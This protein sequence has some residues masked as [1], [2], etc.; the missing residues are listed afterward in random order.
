MQPNRNVRSEI[1][2]ALVVVLLLVVVGLSATLL[3]I[4]TDEPVGTGTAGTAIAGGDKTVTQVSATVRVKETLTA[5]PTV[6]TATPTD[7][8]TDTPTFTP[9]ATDT[10]TNTATYTDT[11]TA[12]DTSTNTPTPTRTTSARTPVSEEPTPT[13]TPT[14]T[15]TGTFTPTLT[16]TFTAT[17][18]P[19]ATASTPSTGVAVL[20]TTIATAA[21]C[22]QPPTWT[23]YQV[24]RGNTLF[25]IARAVG[26]SVGELKTVNC[27]PDADNIAT[28][29]VIFVPRSPN[30][31]VQTGVPRVPDANQL[32]IREGCA[33]AAS[34][35]VAPQPGQR[36]QG[37]FSLAGTAALDEFQYY[38]IEV[39]P[40]FTNVY[41]FYSQSF[42]PVNNGSL[43]AVNAEMFDDGL[44][45]LKLTVVDRT[46]NFIEP[47]VV[48]V[49][50][51]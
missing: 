20:P 13:A 5:T 18:S 46:G 35:I 49:I 4:V 32:L 16:A 40:D 28:G 2:A 30:G 34:Q 14:A 22:T 42:E 12:T 29:D 11:A 39:R 50:F 41:N 23:T 43:G 38:K 45:W 8:P 9:S 24:E 33:L 44:Y 7:T 15:D 25:S 19:T 6:A 37:T 26:S 48:P 47:C 17:T 36:L 3:S 21:P 51:E 1:F 10:P 31:P 27:I